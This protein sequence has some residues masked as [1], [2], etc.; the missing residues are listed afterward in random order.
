FVGPPAKAIEQMG[1]KSAAKAMMADAGVPLVPGYHGAKQDLDTLMGEARSI[2]LPL[3][4]K[5]SAGGGGK[6]MRIVRDF[7]ELQEQLSAAQREAQSA[8]GDGR[9]LL[10]KYLQQPRHVEVQILFDQH[11]KGVYR[12]D[13]ACSL[14]RRQQKTIEEAPAP[15][16]DPE[17]RRAMGEA[18]LRCGEA[19]AYVGAGTVEFLLDADQSFYFMEMNTRLQVEH[20]VTEAISGLDLVEWQLRVAAGEALP[21]SQQDLKISGHAMEARLY[22]EDPERDFLPT[23]GPIRYLRMP[24][25]MENVRVDSGIAEGLDVGSNYDPM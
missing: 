9:V 24:D 25:N 18:A 8:F 7:D 21:W 4:I 23:R 1:S 12:F 5:A 19:T 17:L 14:Q 22:A 15:N 20:P 3:L 2:G 6:G 16:I 11:G 10:E 13:R